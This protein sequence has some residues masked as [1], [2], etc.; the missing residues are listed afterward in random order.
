MSRYENA[1]D[2]MGEALGRLPLKSA[3]ASGKVVNMSPEAPAR[4]RLLLD[5]M[6]RM[7][8]KGMAAA[9]EEQ[10]ARTPALPP[11]LVGSLERLVAREEA[12][13]A[14]LRQQRR[15]KKAGLKG[16]AT[17]QGIDYSHS[18]NLDPAQVAE[19]AACAWLK[20]GCNLIITG[21]VGAGKS[22]LASALTH[23]ACLQGHSALYR[24]LP[25][26]LRELAEARELGELDKYM[27]TMAKVDLLTLDDWGLERLD[28]QQAM[29]VLQIVEE[30]YG[31]KA[32]LIASLLPVRNWNLV[33]D[34]TS[35]GEA[36][37]DRLAAHAPRINLSGGSLRPEYAPGP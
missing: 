15:I 31:Q 7:R 8:L 32:V 18:R 2:I 17:V 6:K 23:A 16:E 27:A 12:E 33:M 35:V 28:H 30:R 25:E 5:K 13:R 14:R 21:P 4:T 36:I 20:R 11:A 37:T 34:G 19:L 26:L 10:M 9:L 1:P 24:R 3:A 29:D 22:F